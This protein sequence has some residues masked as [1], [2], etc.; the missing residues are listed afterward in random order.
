MTRKLRMNRVVIASK[1]VALLLLS[2]RL[3]TGQ[4]HNPSYEDMYV[5]RATPQQATPAAPL[6]LTFTGRFL[7]DNKPVKEFSITIPSTDVCEPLTTFVRT[8]AGS[9]FPFRREAKELLFV[10]DVVSRTSLQR[11]RVHLYS[12][13]HQ[14]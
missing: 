11:P 13:S 12:P 6:T 10:L 8:N 9:A 7:Q 3:A 5:L 14:G 2:P 4:S 1:F